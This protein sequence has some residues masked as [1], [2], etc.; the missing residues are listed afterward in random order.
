MNRSLLCV[1]HVIITITI[2]TFAQVVGEKAI[3]QQTRPCLLF[4]VD[5][6][7]INLHGTLWRSK[8]K[9][10]MLEMLDQLSLTF[11]R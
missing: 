11:K 10:K 8:W 1:F 5:F 3:R 7:E 6:S 4:Q 9:A 2:L